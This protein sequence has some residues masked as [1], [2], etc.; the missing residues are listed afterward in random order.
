MRNPDVKS[1]C[2]RTTPIPSAT[3]TE[4]LRT[5]TLYRHYEPKHD[6]VW[7]SLARKRPIP[8]AC[9]SR[10]ALR[11]K[12]PELGV[13]LVRALVLLLTHG[14]IERIAFDPSPA[15]PYWAVTTVST[16]GAGRHY[17]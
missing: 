10:S 4:I 7:P 13:G 16:S 15:F 11:Q 6:A 14:A 1:G 5:Y 17:L 9:A 3:T 2:E 8:Q 12:P